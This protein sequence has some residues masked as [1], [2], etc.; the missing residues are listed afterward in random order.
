MTAE[1]RVFMRHDATLDIPGLRKAHGPFREDCYEA[2]MLCTFEPTF[3]SGKQDG[4]IRE[5]GLFVKLG[6]K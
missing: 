4:I 6:P 1:R 2:E 5:T 3:Y